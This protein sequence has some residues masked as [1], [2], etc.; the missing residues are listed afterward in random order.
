MSEEKEKD[1]KS[2]GQNGDNSSD[3]IKELGIL[4]TGSGFKSE[5]QYISIIGCVEGH[6]V[7]PQ[8]NKTTQTFQPQEVCCE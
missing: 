5:Y 8:E 3:F 4:T 2:G 6:M 7:L 1:K